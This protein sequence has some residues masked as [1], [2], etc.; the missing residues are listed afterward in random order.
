[1]VTGLKIRCPKGRAGSTPALG[2]IPFP[3]VFTSSI[4]LA[5]GIDSVELQLRDV[6]AEEY[7][8][9]EGDVLRRGGDRV[10]RQRGE[11]SR[12]VF[13]PPHFVG[14]SFVVEEDKLF[15]V[16]TVSHFSSDTQMAQA[17]DC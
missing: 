4:N 12:R 14:V 6:A 15:D 2:T 5:L 16:V 10:D 1:M 13:R 3:K 9:C 8:A 17:G 7:Q 11:S